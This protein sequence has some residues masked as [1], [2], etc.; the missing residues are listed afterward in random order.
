MKRILGIAMVL[1]LVGA[2]TVVA[3]EVK[4]GKGAVKGKSGKAQVKANP[5]NI[6]VIDLG[7]DVKLEM[8]LIPAGKFMM[9]SKKNPVDP[10]SNIKAKQP[11]ENEV[12][13]H[14]VTITKSFYMGK[15]EVTQDQWFE[16]MGENP[17]REKGRKLP[18]TDV[19]WKDCQEFIK[20]LNAK[21][22]GVYRLPTEAEWEYACRA[23]TTTA[24]SFGDQITPKDANY[25]DSKIGKP[26]A[27]GS[28]KPNAF[29]LYDMHGNVWEWCEDWYGDY[30]AGPVIDPRGTARGETHVLRGGAFK[31]FEYNP[32]SH[33]SLRYHFPLFGR[34]NII[35]FRL[36]REEVSGFIAQEVKPGK[37]EVVDLGKNVKLEMVL[38]PAGKFLMG[39]PAS[40]KGIS[41]DQTQLKVTLSKPYYMGKYEVTQEQ[42]QAVMGNNPSSR[43]K[44]AKLPV[45]DVSWKD[46]Q[47][48]I[49]K[50]NGKTA[51]GYRLP[52]EAE[53]EYACR[54]G[55]TTTY[56]FGDKLTTE[57]ANV[58]PSNGA[59]VSP[60]AVT[61]GSYKP[62]AF[63]LYDMHGNVSEWCEDWFELYPTG[64]VTDPK[65]PS[66]GESRRILRGGSFI[67]PDKN[68]RSF[69]RTYFTPT[70]QHRFTG[71]RLV[72]TEDIKANALPTV[73]QPEPTDV[74][75]SKRSLLVS[76]FTEIKAQ[77]VQKKVAKRLQKNVEE[78]VDLGK[79]VKLDL[80]LIPAGRFMMG[81]SDQQK[82]MG[83]E[84]TLHDVT[85]SKHYYIGKY[86]VT[87]E[88]WKAVMG[89]NPS[90]Y[91]EEKLPV[92]NVSWNNC[93]EFIKRLNAKT[94]GGY[95]LPTEAEWEFAC[96][97]GTETVFS[98]GN[99]IT[100]KDAIFCIGSSRNLRKVGSYKP[101]AFGLYD[102]HGNVSEW[103]EDWFEITPTGAVTD[104]K[105]PAEA[106]FSTGRINRGGIS[107]FNR[108]SLSPEK[109]DSLCGFRLARTA[110][111]KA[112][113]SPIAPI[114]V[115]QSKEN[116]LVSPFT[117][118]K[119][120]E[121]QKEVAKSLQTEVEVKADLEKRVKIEMILIPAGK[122]KMGASG[123]DHDVTLTKP[124]YMGKYEV[125]QEQWEAVM[126]YNTSYTKGA[127]LPVTDI[128]WLEC[129]AFIIK[130][131]SK[132]KGGY[133]LPTEAEWEYACRAGTTG[134]Y[135]Y[136]DYL[137][138]KD[139]N[140]S[141][142]MID[143]TLSVG[144]YKPNA[145]GLYDMHGNVSEW[146]EDWSADYT[147]RAV[148]DPKGPVT[149]VSGITVPARVMR[150]GHFLSS[151]SDVRS[152]YRYSSPPNER[153][154]TNG[155]RLVKDK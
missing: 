133:R 9:G 10:F 28:Y 128:S 26:V 117:E 75:L 70:F 55:T 82:G 150:G 32:A 83:H 29:G 80:V 25:D 95:K 153:F 73:T 130:L 155:F 42:W 72:R 152:S 143:K 33:S 64:A 126:E 14:E 122:F 11:P 114:E 3:Q 94:D 39:A 85:I 53:W 5:G 8:V 30:P 41:N 17:S 102:M 78:E 79:G 58:F 49:K 148:T 124:F 135:S 38:I 12:P 116:F 88:Q 66:T 119:A 34:L 4:P 103:C 101:N 144:M 145:F 50:L 40:E 100:P 54:A 86:E 106:W 44:G 59:A 46:C 97:A 51:G 60:V 7:K 36:V 24:Y 91:S 21:T 43:T 110:E 108:T 132:T 154:S 138:L 61:V 69:I 123:Q 27:A 76:P 147:P 2:L 125:T 149:G 47:E 52:T 104:P 131:N 67:S 87:Q 15:Y 56:F 35:G 139:A 19:T 98:F 81:Q 140:F 92:T 45:T 71:F 6:K 84:A 31:A 93:Q 118:T 99:E 111:I 89:D 136:G 1:G 16:I 48:F 112:G 141:N 90:S 121:V 137:T 115:I 65:G 37:G 113:A 77:E 96:R 63:G 62:N 105:G 146:C 68:A 120:K 107:S 142:K 18:V 20:K 109:T 127:K 151:K 74:I 22:N 23:G 134:V 129:Q 57:D 13:Q